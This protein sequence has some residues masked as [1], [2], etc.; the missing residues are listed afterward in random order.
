LS[1]TTKTTA[2]RIDVSDYTDDDEIVVI[3]RVRVDQSWRGNSHVVNAR[4]NPQYRAEHNGYIVQG[5]LDWYSVPVLLHKARTG[6]GEE[7]TITKEKYV[8]YDPHQIPPAASDDSSS[9][10]EEDDDRKPDRQY[11]G[12]NNGSHNNDPT[13]EKKTTADQPSSTSTMIGW[14]VLSVLVL[15]TAAYI[16]RRIVRS[17]MRQSR[18]DRVR[19]F[20]YD[21]AAVTPGLNGYVDIPNSDNQNGRHAA[22]ELDLPTI[23]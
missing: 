22:G 18:R 7:S 13:K 9:G 5:R 8:R 1:T 3:V 2:G 16:G 4:T 17:I 6:E 14:M 23:A 11:P 12:S 21:K 15:V 10:N 20:I 19:D